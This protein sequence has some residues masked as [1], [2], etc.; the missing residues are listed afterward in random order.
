MCMYTQD[1][2]KSYATLVADIFKMSRLNGMILRTSAALWSEHVS[3]LFHQLCNIKLHH[4]VN[5]HPSVASPIRFQDIIATTVTSQW[6]RPV[7]S[8]LYQM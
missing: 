6:P 7:P 3:S 4:L 8:S 5:E 2:P 1:G